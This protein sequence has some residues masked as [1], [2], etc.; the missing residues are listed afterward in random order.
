MIYYRHLLYATDYQLPFIHIRFGFHLILYIIR[1]FR[2]E[3]VSR[4][5]LNFID[6]IDKVCLFPSFLR[7]VPTDKANSLRIITHTKDYL[8]ESL[9]NHYFI[10]SYFAMLLVQINRT[11]YHID[12]PVFYCPRTAL[13]LNTIPHTTVQT[14]IL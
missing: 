2:E 14:I 9:R 3:I 6:R 13:L 7:L 11:T 12:L 8:K 5:S 10:P 4:N 1:Q